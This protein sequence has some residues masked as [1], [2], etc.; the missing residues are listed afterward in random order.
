MTCYSFKF[1]QITNHCFSCAH[2]QWHYFL[3]QLMPPSRSLFWTLSDSYRRRLSPPDIGPPG[4]YKATVIR[5]DDQH[6]QA[7]FHLCWADTDK[8]N[9]L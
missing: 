5:Q 9:E 2:F 1:N 3:L 8:A 6:R 4:A 7:P